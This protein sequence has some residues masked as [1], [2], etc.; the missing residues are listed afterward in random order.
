M[1]FSLTQSHKKR[2]WRAAIGLDQDQ[3]EH[4]LAPFQQAYFQIF[5]STLAE[6]LVESGINYCIRDEREL[7][8]FTLFSLK[9]GL[10]Y[11]N[12]GLIAGMEAPSAHKNQKLGLRVLKA[13]LE[14]LG[15]FPMRDAVQVDDLKEYFL[16]KG[17]DQI[18]IDASEQIK[19]RPTEPNSR[20]LH[21]SGKKKVILEKSSP[22]LVSRK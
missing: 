12:L 19:Q 22:S 2:Q 4:L 21:Y 14:S 15:Y 8:L 16:K 17:I 6:R 20:K 5:G 10:S 18:L 1:L 3:F 11:D 7:L 13:T 9:S